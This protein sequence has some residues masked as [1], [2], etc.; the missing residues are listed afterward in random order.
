MATQT[1]WTAN[2]RPLS[3]YSTGAI[4]LHWA[5]AAFILFN[6]ATGFFHHDLPRLA[7]AIHISSG[8][9]ILILSLVRIAWRLTHRPPPFAS[10]MPAWERWAAHGV[11]ALLYVAM[12]AMPL[13]GWAMVSASPPPGSP[14]AAAADAARAAAHPGEP[15]HA[16][17]GPSFWFVAPLPLIKPLQEMGRTPEG[18]PAQKAKHHQIGAVHELGGWILLALLVLH[19][20]GA[21]K[22]QL[23]DRQREFARMGIGEAE[24]V[25]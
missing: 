24:L 9:T 22:H 10:T 15:A 1:I 11:H 16:A 13:T 20:A 2:P 21:L 12:L 14:G 17:Q 6:L 19:I 8:I 25:P 23:I 5:I 7:I 4:L 18:L 3:R